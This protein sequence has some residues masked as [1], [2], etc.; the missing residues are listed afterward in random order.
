[1]WQKLDWFLVVALTL[2]LPVQ[3]FVPTPVGHVTLISLSI[4]A[5]LPVARSAYQS[6]LDRQIATDLLASIALIASFVA[7]EWI[8]AAFINLML[9][10]ARMFGDYTANNARK[11]IQSLLDLKPKTIRVQTPEGIVTKPIAEARLNDLV[12]VGLGERIPVD[13]IIVA[14]ESLID[15]SSLTGESL[16]VAKTVGDQ[17][18]SSTLNTANTLTIKAE[19]V[20]ADTTLEKIIRLVETSQTNKI[21]IQ[22]LANRFANWYIGSIL[23]LSI[24]LYLFTHDHILVLAFLLIACA[25]DLAI[26]IPLAFSSAIGQAAKQGIIIKGA[27]FLEGLAQADTIFF[28]KTGTLTTGKI[29]VSNILPIANTLSPEE[30]LVLAASLEASST[31]PIAKAILYHAKKQQVTLLATVNLQENPGKGIQADIDGK[32]TLC[33]NLPFLKTNDI[34]FSSEQQA[35]LEEHQNDPSLQLFLAQDQQFIG[36]IFLADTPRPET[37]ATLQELTQLGITHQT[38]LTGDT[39]AVAQS[40]A[41]ITGIPEFQANL[42]PD[43]KVRIVHEALHSGGKVL[44]IGDGVNDAAALAQADI[45]IAMGAVGSDIAIEAA[46]IA[47]MNDR[48]DTLPQAIRLGKS[49]LTV[50]RQNFWI[51]GIVNTIG[52]IL[53]FTAIIGPSGAAAYNFLT[54]FIPIANSFRVFR[55]NS[56]KA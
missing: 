34:L 36:I 22:T 26:A 35:I 40:I 5:L 54:D 8:S 28:D 4:V 21:G 32:T 19:K 55:A 24:A 41:A 20:G 52:L 56:L 45:G 39:A 2:I 1:M 51:W 50:A 49:T 42:T 46:D 10:A 18:L 37:R 9:T 48:L 31:H 43:D 47:L 17:V 6:I 13:G 29:T 27:R 44:M 15:Q 38:M 11:A 33:G 30:I 7:A 12:L 16:P 14:G 53:V 25:D 23:V 3:Y